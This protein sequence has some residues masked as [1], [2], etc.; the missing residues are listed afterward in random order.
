MRVAIA[1][2]HGTIAQQLAKMLVEREDEVASLIRDPDQEGDITDLGAEPVVCDLEESDGEALAEAIGSADA[3]VFAAGAGPGSGPERKETV[4]YE[5]AVK[6]LEAA[7]KLGAARYVM[8]SSMNADADH[9][10]EET[11][12][13]YLRAKGRAD[14]EVRDSGISHVIVRPGK[15]TDDQ[16]TGRVQIAEPPNTVD[17]SEIPREDVAAV[18]AAA[19]RAETP[20]DSTIDVVSGE[21]PIEEAVAYLGGGG[22]PGNRLR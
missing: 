6:L 21:T 14:E 19:L 18:I 4:D 10:G 12:D 9:E 11:M 2:G 5:G 17:G 1:G 7:Q 3:V 16:G 8:V 22:D 15:L 20:R 13:V